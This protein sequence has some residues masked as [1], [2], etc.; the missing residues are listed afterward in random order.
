MPKIFTHCLPTIICVTLIYVVY[1]LLNN[2]FM[3][4]VCMV[5]RQLYLLSLNCSYNYTKLCN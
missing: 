2:H 4:F 1:V 5:L 3:Y